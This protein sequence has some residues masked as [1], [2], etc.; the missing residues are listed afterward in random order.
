MEQQRRRRRRGAKKEKKG[1]T[2]YQ[3]SKRSFGEF[4]CPQCKR[5]WMSANTW[6][7][8]GQQCNKCNINVY[9]YKQL[10]LNKAGGLNKSDPSKKHPQELCQKCRSL[11][12]Y[13]GAREYHEPAAV[14]NG[15]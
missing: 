3:G 13:C 6:A 15:E 10:P 2:P 14:V 12:Y 4:R 7:N 11:K 1:L 5:G 8:C 9:P